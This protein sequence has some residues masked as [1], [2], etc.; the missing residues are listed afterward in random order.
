[1]CLWA[2]FRVPRGLH[3]TTEQRNKKT[4]GLLFN[5]F[6]R[7]AF[8][9]QL[10]PEFLLLSRPILEEVSLPFAHVLQGCQHQFPAVTMIWP[11]LS[12]CIK[13]T[14]LQVPHTENPLAVQ[15]VIRG[16]G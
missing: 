9:F 11:H 14:V 7:T 10:M 12:S 4:F 8:S 6:D 1:V 5:R 2:L 13:V 15:G 3:H 16:D